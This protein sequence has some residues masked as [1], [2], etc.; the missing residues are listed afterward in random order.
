MRRIRVFVLAGSL[1]V[2][3]APAPA[4]AAS[5]TFAGSIDSVWITARSVLISEGW[6][7]AEE[8][9]RL[10]MIITEPRNVDYR[11]FGVY[12]EGTRHRLKLHLRPAG[13]GQTSVTV[14]RELFREQRILWTKERVPF[15]FKPAN[16]NIESSLLETLG[17]L[18]PVARP[19]GAGLSPAPAPPLERPAPSPPVP[20]ERSRAATA[21]SQTA[22][23][24]K[25][26]Y[27]VTGSGGSV[28]VTYRNAQSGTDRQIISTLPWEFSF[29]GKGGSP[30]YLSAVAQGTST[31]SVTCEILVDDTSRSQSMSVGAS[32][33]ATCSTPAP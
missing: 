29:S 20:P 4:D 21:P 32:A 12:G 8:D 33:V 23:G 30:L 2:A 22:P 15:P 24:A 17:H 16:Q 19:V 18:T 27:R 1:A 5:Q 3:A 14:D 9:R 10:G 25:V 6:D 26:S 31:A 11:N 7:I 28:Q 13:P